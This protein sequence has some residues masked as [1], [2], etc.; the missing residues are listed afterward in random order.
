MKGIILAGGSG[1][2]LYPATKSLCK[3]LLPVYDKPMIY[4]PLTTLMLAGI[5]DILIITTPHDHK[6][7]Q[8]LLGEGTLWGI[9]LT[10]QVQ[11]RPEGIAQAFILAENFIKNDR[12]CLILGDNLFFGNGLGRILR[13]IKEGTKGCYLFAYYVN[14]PRAYGVVN[15]S[16][17]GK[18][19]SLEEKPK[20]PQ[21]NYAVTGLYFYDNTVVDIAKSLAPSKRGELEIMDVNNHYLKQSDLQVVLLERG[22]SWL[23]TGNAKSLLDAANFVEVIESR[24]GLKIGCPEEVAWRMGYISCEALK[25]LGHQLSKSSYGKYLLHIAQRTEIPASC[26]A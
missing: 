26:D 12:V 25:Q 8:Y 20:D 3:Q 23:D 19:L 15:F 9:N 21:S 10:Y 18:V 24:Q 14:D 11:A 17:N 7:F 13:E 4:Y 6:A 2:R 22:M 1:T 16:K 5:R